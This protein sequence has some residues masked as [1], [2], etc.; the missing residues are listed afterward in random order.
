MHS[1]PEFAISFQTDKHEEKRVMMVTVDGGPDEN[2][3]YEKTFQRGML[4]KMVLMHFSWQQMLLAVL[5]S[6]V[7]NEGWLNSAK[8]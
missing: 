5:H 1:L 6:I 7:S 2:L 4:L 8:S 3:R